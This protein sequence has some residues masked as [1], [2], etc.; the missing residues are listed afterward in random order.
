MERQKNLFTLLHVGNTDEPDEDLEAMRSCKPPRIMNVELE[1][2]ILKKLS[3]CTVRLNP[4]AYLFLG[5]VCELEFE[6]L[7][8][9]GR[10]QLNL[11]QRLRE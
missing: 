3:G 5:R 4:T 9:H 10:D 1:E 7:E 8:E 11:K 2:G 6:I